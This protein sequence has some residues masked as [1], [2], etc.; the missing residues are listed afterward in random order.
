MEPSRPTRWHCRWRRHNFN[1]KRWHE[2]R[3]MCTYFIIFS[4]EIRARRVVRTICGWFYHTRAHTAHIPKH[5][6]NSGETIDVCRFGYVMIKLVF[7]ELLLEFTHIA[8]TFCNDC[9]QMLRAQA[10]DCRASNRVLYSHKT[11]N[12]VRIA[13]QS[14]T[15][16]FLICINQSANPWPHMKWIVGRIWFQRCIHYTS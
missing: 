10:R 5:R 4:K 6:R 12:V 15:F 7:V 16:H 11:H 3:K 2:Q 1:A 14:H 9:H 13:R 8:F